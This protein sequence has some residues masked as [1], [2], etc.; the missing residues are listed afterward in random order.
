MVEPEDKQE[1]KE[2]QDM[3]AI[4]PAFS[5]KPLLL[6]L[7]WPFNKVIAVVPVSPQDDE[8]EDEV[9]VVIVR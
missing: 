2:L 5:A 1:P 8:D 9:A 6:W 7:S 3:A 4:S